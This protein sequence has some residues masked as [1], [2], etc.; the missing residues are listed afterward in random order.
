M[1]PTDTPHLRLR[2]WREHRGMTQR[3]LHETT[4]VR[5]ATISNIENRKTK[6]VDFATLATL[7]KALGVEP[8][9]LFVEPGAK[10]T[11]R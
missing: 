1:A 7:A 2:A 8:A 6:G 5:I 4:G 9:C 10:P 3:S 11:C